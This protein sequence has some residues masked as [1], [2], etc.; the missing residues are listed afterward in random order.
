M[1]IMLSLLLIKVVDDF[2][3]SDDIDAIVYVNAPEQYKSEVRHKKYPVRIQVRLVKIVLSTRETE[4]LMTSLL[5]LKKFTISDLKWLYAKRWGVE[6]G[7]FRFKSHLEAEVFSSGKVNCIKKD[8]LAVVFLQVLEAILN[9]ALD[10]AMRLES[11][12]KALKCV[13]HVNKSGAYSM[14]ENHLVS[15]FLLEESMVKTNFVAFQKEINLLRSPIRLDRHADRKK[16]TDAQK[17]RHVKYIL[18]RR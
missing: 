1:Q 17:V 10:N 8:F 16:L 5:D 11:E 3:K 4:L 13:Y 14:L 2:V 12:R 6:S 7:F 18:K 15:F 9:K